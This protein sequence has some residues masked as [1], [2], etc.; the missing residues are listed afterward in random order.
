MCV[1]VCECV[2][3]REK[4]RKRERERERECDV[5]GADLQPV[6]PEPEARQPEEP[7][8]QV[9]LMSNRCISCQ[10]GVSH[11]SSRQT[12]VSH[13]KQVYIMSAAGRR[14]LKGRR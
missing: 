10:T 5:E 3:E 6:A 13:V 4:E 8:K 11:V 12:G 14:L 2:S 7:E 9:Y 1:C